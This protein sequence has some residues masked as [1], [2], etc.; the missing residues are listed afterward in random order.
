MGRDITDALDRLLIEAQHCIKELTFLD[1]RQVQLVAVLLESDQKRLSEALRIVE[2]GK[3]G[4]DLYE[5]NRKTVL[6]I[7]H[8]LAVNCKHFQDS[9]DAARLRSN[10]AHLKKKVHHV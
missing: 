2:D 10:V 4:P 9:V 8:I 6:K 3:T 5:S 1:Q 7:S